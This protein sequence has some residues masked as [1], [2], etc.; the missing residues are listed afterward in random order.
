M[1]ETAK[2]EQSSAG[3]ARLT[4]QLKL[5]LNFWKLCFTF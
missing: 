5:D 4:D 2:A 3:P 1:D